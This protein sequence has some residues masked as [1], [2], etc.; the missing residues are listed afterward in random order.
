M[1]E[2][3]T[4]ASSG[5]LPPLASSSAA[6]LGI[7]LF[8]VAA[9]VQWP[10]AHRTIVPMDEGH[11]AAAASWMHA[12]KHLYSEI[13]TGIFPGIYLLTY[14]LFGVFGE[15]LLVTRFAAMCVNGLTAVLLWRI[16]ARCTDE[17]WAWVAPVAYVAFVPIAFPI[18]S[19]LNYS[20]LAV[21]AGLGALYFLLRTLETKRAR[22]A[23]GLGLCIAATA[24]TKQNFG[25]LVLIAC[26][27]GGILGGRSA[28]FRFTEWRRLFVTVGLAGLV[29]TVFV[30]AGF[31]AT[32]TFGD[33]IEH[34]LLSLG[35]SQV[36]HF[37]NPIPPI[38]GTHPENDGRFTFLYTPPPMFDDML[39]GGRV[40]GVKP[41]PGVR[42]LAIRLSYGLPLVLLVVAFALAIRDRFAP[43]EAT[44]RATR[45]VLIYGIVF[46]PGIFPSAIWSHLAFVMIPLLPLYVIVGHRLH[47]WLSQ[48]QVDAPVAA[49]RRLA[50]P[51]FATLVLFAWVA[52][53]FESITKVIDRNP[54][55][56]ELERAD[57]YVSDRMAG[58]IGGA[59]EFIERCA[60]PGED[61]FVAPEIP[62][63]YFLTGRT[64][65][66]PHDLVIPG[67]VDGMRI[68]RGLEDAGVRCVVFNPRM[69][70]EFPPFAQLFP[71][72]ARYLQS[73]F[74]RV[75]T[76][77]GGGTEWYGLMRKPGGAPR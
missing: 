75:E 31:V 70:P 62:V 59:V 32:G 13:H 33:L 21:M 43:S 7:G 15:D 54:T 77:Q 26:L 49:S 8:V 52:A 44:A 12:G 57:L 37:N 17:R 55:P 53:G 5:S 10:L 36:E 16:T 22:D 25:G 27:V 4:L 35:G 46:F 66:Q 41:T 42:S 24:L 50:V 72:L 61:V 3:S 76:F 56:L 19:M 47:A 69:Y 9:I 20:T 51:T 60:P 1:R 64:T 14:S 39:N 58:L 67:N 74:V 29:P 40:L 38:L 11:L 45:A 18:L 73:R 23:A 6:P 68:A 63:V 28:G 30:I 34:T 71:D 48:R 2:T 65:P